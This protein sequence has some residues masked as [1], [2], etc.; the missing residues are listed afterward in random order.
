MGSI[1]GEEHGK[2][3]K[4]FLRLY[5]KM[6]TYLRI[7]K[8]KPILRRYFIM[9]SFDGTMT[10]L[11][12][13][14]GSYISYISDPRILI[15]VKIVGGLAMAI[16]GFT[17]TYMTESA[18]RASLLND[19]EDSMLTDLSDTIYGDASRYISFFAAM[20]DGSAPMLA[21]LPGLIPFVLTLFGVIPIH[22]AFL[23]SIV[24]DLTILFLLGVFLGRISGKNAIRSGLRMILAGILVTMLAL[25]I[26]GG[27]EG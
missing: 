13:T 6:E 11:G 25:L 4:Y 5:L 16:S 7:T 24:A 14:I 12:I 17:G 19:L 27:F 23:T 2:W 26:N 21:S 1:S 20:V 9:N 15:G 3:H 18:E 8:S 22:Y 10:S